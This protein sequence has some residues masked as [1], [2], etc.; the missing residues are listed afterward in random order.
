MGDDDVVGV[1][2]GS[3]GVAD[4]LGDAELVWVA[5]GLGDGDELVGVP[6]G[7]V[8]VADALGDGD[9]VDADADGDGDDVVADALGDGDALTVVLPVPLTCADPPL[10]NGHETEALPL[11]SVTLW[12]WLVDKA[13]ASDWRADCS[14]S[15]AACLALAAAAC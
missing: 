3:V 4:A 12:H 6:E 9:D 7:S 13:F 8:G 15:L 1:P 2:A 10:A 11:A 14:L 5:D